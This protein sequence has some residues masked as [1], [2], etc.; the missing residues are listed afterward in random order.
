M[1]EL[2]VD[3]IKTIHNS[4]EKRFSKM[5]KGIV[6]DKE[7]LLHSLVEK[8][9]RTLYGSPSPY[10]DIFTK[11][12][13]LMEALT[14]W[15]IFVDGNKR[16]GLMTAFI[17]LYVNQYYLAIPINSVKFTIK[18][19]DNRDTDPESTELLIKEIAEWLRKHSATDE[20]EFFAKAGQ[21][22]F[23]P[24]LKLIILQKIGFKKRVQRTVNDWF[25]LDS[26]GDY[27]GEVGETTKYLI[28]VM[29]ATFKQLLQVWEEKRKNRKKRLFHKNS[30]TETLHE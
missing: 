21:Y 26:H 8:P 2:T 20:L 3:N 28:D 6:L 24:I 23:W 1:Q 9:N 5:G 19:A 4:L 17:Y 7:P 27:Q 11:A 30:S 25:A 29:G 18:I 12:A 14:R 22:T 16:T 13:V 15:H 10:E